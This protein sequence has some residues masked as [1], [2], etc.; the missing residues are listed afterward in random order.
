MAKKSDDGWLWLL[1]LAA[2]GGIVIADD[3]HTKRKKE[4]A[5]FR[6]AL[7][8][9]QE[10]LARREAELAAL[11]VQLG[12]KNEQVRVLAQEVERLRGQLNALRAA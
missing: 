8:Q 10:T 11:Q 9:L 3:Q 5:Y 1:G 6:A 4:E 12:P 2:V 7:T